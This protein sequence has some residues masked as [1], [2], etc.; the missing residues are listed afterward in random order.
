MQGLIKK[1]WSA[2][3]H[4]VHGHP[5]AK[6]PPKRLTECHFLE[7]IPATGKKA[8]P[9]RR[10]M[11]CT[12][13]VKHACLKMGVSK[14]ITQFSTYNLAAFF[15]NIWDV[16]LLEYAIKLQFL[17]FRVEKKI[18]KIISHT[19]LA[20]S[21]VAAQLAASQEGLSSVSK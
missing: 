20:M 2:V 18:Y 5:S 4:P 13:N 9:H 14:A 1:H 10:V 12:V 8:K 15:T 19:Y 21:S 6:L 16:Q 11:C 3:P 17:Q 7:K